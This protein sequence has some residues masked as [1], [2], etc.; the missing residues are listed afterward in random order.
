MAGFVGL[1]LGVSLKESQVPEHGDVSLLVDRYVLHTPVKLTDSEAWFWATDQ[2]GIQ[3]LAKVIANPHCFYEELAR[4]F[5][6]SDTYYAPAC[7]DHIPPQGLSPQDLHALARLNLP[8]A[9][10]AN[11]SLL[12][13]EHPGDT[14]FAEA[15]GSMAASEVVAA[16]LEITYALEAFHACGCAQGH[17]QQ[18]AIFFDEAGELRFVAWGGVGTLDSHDNNMPADVLADL[19]DFGKHILSATKI[20]GLRSLGRQLNKGRLDLEQARRRIKKVRADITPKGNLQIMRGFLRPMH[21][22]GWAALICLALL[23]LGWSDRGKDDFEA[24]MLDS[25]LSSEAKVE[26]LRLILGRTVDPDHR[27]NLIRTIAQIQEDDVVRLMSQADATRPVAVLTFDQNPMLIGW[28]EIYRPG[29][30]VQVGSKFGY[31]AK[32]DVNRIKISHQGAFSYLNLEQPAFMAA[33]GFDK[34]TALVWDNPK[35]YKRLLEA[36]SQIQDVELMDQSE[37]GLAQVSLAG[38]F[39]V[40]SVEKLLQDLSAVSPIVQN[41]SGLVYEGSSNDLGIYYRFPSIYATVELDSLARQLE[42]FLGIEIVVEPSIKS[43]LVNISGY[44]I[45]WQELL[46]ASGIDWQVDGRAADRKI[47]FSSLKPAME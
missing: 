3:L 18:D 23:P 6:V 35:N 42:A 38:A 46:E 19:Q 21:L 13:L 31:I 34:N 45:T 39:W 26:K 44:N 14:T 2:N 7:L 29:D 24:V 22:V 10:D 37:L 5:R 20:P 15:L 25:R 33:A 28:E 30:W 9:V 47:L 16:C 43:E 1:F 4:L 12:I 41:T 11:A 17:V 8:F 40:S 32:I 36:L 27:D